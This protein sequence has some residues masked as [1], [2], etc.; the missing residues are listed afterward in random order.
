MIKNDKGICL[1]RKCWLFTKTRRFP[2]LPTKVVNKSSL[3]PFKNLKP[4]KMYDTDGIDL[5]ISQSDDN[6]SITKIRVCYSIII[7]DPRHE[8][9]Y[10]LKF[11]QEC[12]SIFLGLKFF[13][14]F[15][16][17][18]QNFLYFLGLKIFV[19]HIEFLWMKNTQYWKT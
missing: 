18:F 16:W 15:L 13:E 12:L 11:K 14:L 7:P 8:G 1:T 9:W 10:M 4:F 5:L 19:P 17:A 6:A 2:K 3:K